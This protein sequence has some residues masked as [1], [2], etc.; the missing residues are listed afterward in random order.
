MDFVFLSNKK[1]TITLF[2]VLRANLFPFY[3]DVSLIMN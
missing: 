2:D 1:V 3:R